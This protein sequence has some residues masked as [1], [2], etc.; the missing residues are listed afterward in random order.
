M[1]NHKTLRWESN[2]RNKYNKIVPTLNKV[3]FTLDKINPTL[4][5]KITIYSDEVRVKDP[6]AAERGECKTAFSKCGI[7]P[8]V[9]GAMDKKVNEYG[10]K[11]HIYYD[12][13]TYKKAE[14]S[15]KVV[16]ELLT[17]SLTFAYDLAESCVITY[18]DERVEVENAIVDNGV[19]Y[20]INKV[21]DTIDCGDTPPNLG[22]A[23][24]NA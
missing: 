2:Q 6:T 11:Y 20:R 18:K 8:I 24:G 16:D 10:L 22:T 3:L 17:I 7:K 21:V 12:L 5:D 19:V 23:G 4:S 14:Y 1:R 15:G 9:N 13:G